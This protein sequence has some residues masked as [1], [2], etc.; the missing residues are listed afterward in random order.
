MKEHNHL[1]MMFT[2]CW[3]FL[4]TR[5]QQTFQFTKTH[6]TS[7]LQIHRRRTVFTHFV[8]VK[9][10]KPRILNNIKKLTKSDKHE[11]NLDDTKVLCKDRKLVIPRSLQKHVVEWYHH[12][13]QHPGATQLEETLWGAIYYWKV[14]LRIVR[15]YIKNCKKFQVNK[16]CQKLYDKVPTKMVITKPCTP[17]V[18]TLLVHTHSMV[19]WYSHWIHVSH[20]D[21]PCH[22]CAALSH[23]SCQGC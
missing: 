14:M 22:Y 13:L 8:R 1:W 15:A 11:I 23:L 5:H 4:L 20:T 9:L 16:K 6:W 19:R 7:Y 21:W 12:Y 2:Q 3:N 17:C 10:L 18:S